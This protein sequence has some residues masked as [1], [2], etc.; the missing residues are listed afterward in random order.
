MKIKMLSISAFVWLAL[1]SP[2]GAA[3][4]LG[5]WIARVLYFEGSFPAM[6]G[7][8]IFD[9]KVDGSKVTG[10][11]IYP[12]RDPKLAGPGVYPQ[13]EA[14]ISEGRISEDKISFVVKRTVG[15]KEIRIVYTGIVGLNE[16]QCTSEVQDETGRP[17]EFTAKREFQ[18]NND[19]PIPRNRRSLP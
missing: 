9:F 16:I 3:D 19:L 15:E 5:R 6:F 12:K 13:G 7:D 4:I 17:Q 11:V 10:T 18:R 14:A 2:A 8:T 1:I